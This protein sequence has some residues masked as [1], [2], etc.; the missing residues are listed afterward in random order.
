M[1]DQLLPTQPFKKP[2]AGGNIVRINAINFQFR[3]DYAMVTFEPAF[4]C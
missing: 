2:M 3:K 1:P 4:G